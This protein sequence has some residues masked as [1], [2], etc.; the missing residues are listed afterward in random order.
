METFSDLALANQMERPGLS[1]MLD[2]LERNRHARPLVLMDDFTRL[3]N[4]INAQIALCSAIED[5]GG[6][7]DAPG[8]ELKD[9]SFDLGEL[10]TTEE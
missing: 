6:E 8:F 4:H 5:A 2:F 1:A 3:A 7:I 9:I 10:L